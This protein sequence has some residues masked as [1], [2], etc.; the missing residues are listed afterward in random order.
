VL[1]RPINV[2]PNPNP[3]PK[4]VSAEYMQDPLTDADFKFDWFVH[5]FDGSGMH[6]GSIKRVL[7]TAKERLQRE[8]ICKYT[9][10]RTY[11]HC[12]HCYQFIAMVM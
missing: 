11:V 12:T 2:N 10:I 4:G 1:E 6:E 9:Y 3:N 8:G 5:W 7:A